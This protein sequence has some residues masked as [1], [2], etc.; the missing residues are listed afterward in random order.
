[1]VEPLKGGSARLPV[2]KHPNGY[3]SVERSVPGRVATFTQLTLRDPDRLQLATDQ[4]QIDLSDISQAGRRSQITAVASSAFGLRAL[5][6][7]CRRALALP[8]E[9]TGSPDGQKNI[10]PEKVN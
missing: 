8:S 4:R 6:S 9:F 7:S 3:A 5:L 10:Q 1:M 2:R